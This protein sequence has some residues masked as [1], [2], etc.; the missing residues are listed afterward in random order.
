MIAGGMESM[1]NTPY[2][3]KRG[4]TPYG[5]IEMQVCTF[6]KHLTIKK[7]R[8]YDQAMPQSQVKTNQGTN[9]SFKSVANKG[10]KGEI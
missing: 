9:L 3:M 7:I 8:E 2:Y 4:M 1:S 5:K 6:T 10:R